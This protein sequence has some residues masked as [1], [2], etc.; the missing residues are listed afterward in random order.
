MLI[1]QHRGFEGVQRDYYWDHVS[2]CG[3]AIHVYPIVQEHNRGFMDV[4]FHRRVLEQ[5]HTL[6]GPMFGSALRYLRKRMMVDIR[7]D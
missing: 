4:I 1:I 3:S 7:P 5:R 2:S 6:V